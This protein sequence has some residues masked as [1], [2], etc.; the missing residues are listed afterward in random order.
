[1]AS[2]NFVR[3][4]GQLLINIER[5]KFHKSEIIWWRRHVANLV[6]VHKYLWELCGNI[7][8]ACLNTQSHK[9]TT[10]GPL[11]GNPTDRGRGISNF[12]R[13]IGQLQPRLIGENSVW[14]RITKATGVIP[15]HIHHKYI[16][17]KN[18]VRPDG[19]LLINIERQKSH[20]FEIISWRRHVANFVY[21]HKHMWKLC[22]NM[23]FFALTH[24]HTHTHTHTHTD[25]QTNKQKINWYMV[26]NVLKRALQLKNHQN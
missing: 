26:Q 13:S 15:E 7:A 19:Q 20:K 21:V 5:Q 12:V 3:P 10:R 22:G 23:G 16:A 24:R 18:F 1:M 9:Q 6:H 17:S 14:L 25:P 8:F 4:D 11:R 2:K